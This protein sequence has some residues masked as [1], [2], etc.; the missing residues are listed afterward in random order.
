[1]VFF[2]RLSHVKKV[3]GLPA[4]QA[5]GQDICGNGR[6][7]GSGGTGGTA[8]SGGTGGTAGSGPIL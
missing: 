3:I 7:A 8:G 5:G 4:E 2:L 6:N 1:M